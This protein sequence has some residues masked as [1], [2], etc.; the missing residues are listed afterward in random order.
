MEKYKLYVLA[1]VIHF[2]AYTWK[3]M[4]YMITYKPILSNSYLTQV[5]QRL[6]NEMWKSNYPVIFLV[7]RCG[8]LKT[9]DD[10]GNESGDNCNCNYRYFTEAYLIN[11]WLVN[12]LVILLIFD[13]L[14]FNL[15]HIKVSWSLLRNKCNTVHSTFNP[16]SFNLISPLSI[17][18]K[19]NSLT[20]VGRNSSFWVKNLSDLC[21]NVYFVKGKFHL[22]PLLPIIR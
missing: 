9:L 7:Y 2:P 4:L 20:G 21:V 22:E 14:I 19:L 13:S 17:C 18:V 16:R 3:T 10:C 15:K 6:I 1:W 8:H 11:D 5:T 12:A